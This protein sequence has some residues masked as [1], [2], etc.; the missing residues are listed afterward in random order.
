MIYIRRFRIPEELKD[1]TMEE[2]S[3]C[4][5]CWTAYPIEELKYC[6]L[7][8]RV[9]EHCIRRL[10]AL[11]KSRESGAGPTASNIHTKNRN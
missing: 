3:F 7:T 2:I 1:K 6:G 4:E 9:C 8:R 10:K 11:N 5:E